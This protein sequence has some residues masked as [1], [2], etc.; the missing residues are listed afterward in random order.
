MTPMMK[1]LSFRM[2]R[3]APPLSFGRRF[4]SPFDSSNKRVVVE[5]PSIVSFVIPIAAATTAT[6]GMTILLLQYKVSE[7][8]ELY[9]QLV[10]V[11]IIQQKLLEE[12]IKKLEEEQKS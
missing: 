12:R 1:N 11:L 5:K 6:T 10:R 9:I 2:L 8:I 7:T 3:R 4:H